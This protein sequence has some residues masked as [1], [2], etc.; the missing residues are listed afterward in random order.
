VSDTGVWGLPEEPYMRRD[1]LLLPKIAWDYG[2][3]ETHV[4]LLVLSR[5]SSYSSIW[6]PRGFW[7]G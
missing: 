6:G 3:I 2:I 7:E 5:H 4:S 1:T